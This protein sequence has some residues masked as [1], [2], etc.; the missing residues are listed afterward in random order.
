MERVEFT[1]VWRELCA[2]FGKDVSSTSMTSMAT[3]YFKRF[4]KLSAEQF[5]DLCEAC[6]ESCDHFPSRK[7]IVAIA[8]EKR[9]FE[10]STDGKR[11]DTYVTVVCSC[12]GS[13]SVKISELSGFHF[14]RCPCMH[15]NYPGP[16]D[17][18]NKS[19]SS[20]FLRDC[21]K[22][23]NGVIYIDEQPPITYPSFV[24]D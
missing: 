14:F 4:E 6:K 2:N 23:S 11:V 19:Y 3:E 18:C 17:M 8:G 20:E 7:Q 9:M 22:A 24:K 15:G 1:S 12:D 5:V 16:Y 10:R 13:F 21:K